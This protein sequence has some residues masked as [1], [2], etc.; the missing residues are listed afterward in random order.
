MMKPSAD[1]PQPVHWNN[2][3]QK[4][5]QQ[6]RSGTLQWNHGPSAG[7][8]NLLLSL[9]VD[10]RRQ[11]CRTSVTVH[12]RIP[13]SLSRS[14]HRA[15]ALRQEVP[16]T[17]CWQH[18][19]RGLLT[20]SWFP[21][22]MRG[23]EL[24]PTMPGHVVVVVDDQAIPGPHVTRIPIP[25]ISMTTDCSRASVKGKVVQKGPLVSLGDEDYVLKAV[26]EEEAVRSASPPRN[27]SIN[28]ILFG[29]LARDF[30]GAVNQGE[31]VVVTGFTAGKSP[32]A[33]KDRLHPCNILLS[34]A[35][36]CL[37]LL[38]C[39]PACTIVS[40]VAPKRRSPR[41]PTSEVS[42]SLQPD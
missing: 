30:S 21:C 23:E 5:Q 36:A 25:G 29:A 39:P 42:L 24:G 38:R 40:P 34:G 28:V 3:W 4:Q 2:G 10:E 31:V 13:E 37:Y 12:P 16:H 6:R 1:R 35:D 41:S 19:R 27:M 8:V 14:D 9:P 26:I 32:T 22:D 11:Y 15:N 20:A 18:V 33:Q 17:T 7:G